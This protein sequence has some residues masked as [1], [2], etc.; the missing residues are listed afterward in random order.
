[1]QQLKI[2]SFDINGP[3]ISIARSVRDLVVLTLVQ[4]GWEL[5]R[6]RPLLGHWDSALEAAPPGTLGEL[7]Y[8]F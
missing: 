6:R 5:V 7:P 2:R 4:G 3:Y 1:M 8:K